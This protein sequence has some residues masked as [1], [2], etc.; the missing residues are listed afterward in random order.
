MTRRDAAWVIA[1]A[2]AVA[3]G[4]AFFPSWASAAE[5]EPYR[6]VFFNA[7]EYRILDSFTAILIPTDDTP[8]AREARVAPFVDFVV[9]AAAEYAPEVQR[10]WRQVL[11][12]L[13][14]QRFGS[15]SASEQN[16]LITRMSAPE[17]DPAKHHA[18]FPAY[19]L[20]KEMTVHAFYTSRAG[21][22]GN[23]EYKGNAYL[24][25]FPACNHPEHHKV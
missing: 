6:P 10:E 3:G 1:R 4:G 22:I 15:L 13:K 12:W 19:R 20:I 16:A 9:N 14:E 17:R 11:G 8:G 18:G 25:E 23:L 5:A 2:V 24:K 21:L 7:E